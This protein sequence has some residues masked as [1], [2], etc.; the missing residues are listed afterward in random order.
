MRRL[1][2]VLFLAVGIAACGEGPS[3]K[4]PTRPGA[5]PYIERI[6]LEGPPRL[7]SVTVGEVVQLRVFA[8]LSD[9]TRQDVTADARFTVVDERVV[10]VAPGGLATAVGLGATGIFASYRNVAAVVGYGVRV[11]RSRNERFD[12]TAVARD[13][14]GAPLSG[15][16]VTAVADGE[17][18]LRITDG[19]G[20]ADFGSMPG[21]ATFTAT[22]LGYADATAVVSGLTG[23]A[24]VTVRMVANPGSYIERRVEDAFDTLDPHAGIVSRTYRIVTR[25]G[26]L[27]DAEVDSHNCDYN[28]TLEIVVRSGGASFTSTGGE[29]YGRVRFV[30]PQDELQLTVR[31][32]KATTFRL[33]FLEPR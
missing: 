8:V 12:L 31:G 11:V 21:F 10:R 6:E 18:W 16:R 1:M 7:E 26:G 27:F 5:L 4:M 9:G 29:C 15:A 19:N 2:A 33:T 25:A 20:F 22:R 3:A 32:H 28:G 23:P 14:H 17:Q 13:E 30:V 24:Q